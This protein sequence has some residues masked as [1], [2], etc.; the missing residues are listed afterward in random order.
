MGQLLPGYR[1]AI[2]DEIK[3]SI[4]S[5][6]SQ[7]YAFAGNPVAYEDTPPTVT[8]DSYNSAFVNNWQMIFGK[9]IAY[10]DIV[11][12]IDNNEW[13]AGTVYNRYDNTVADLTNYYVITP[14]AVVDASRK[15]YKC[16]DVP[17]NGAPSTIAPSEVLNT[18]FT[19]SDGYTWRYITSITSAQYIKTATADYV[20]VIPDDTAIGAAYEHSGV[21]VVAVAN[22]GVGYSCHLEGT[23]RGITN[24]TYIQ[25]SSAPYTVSFNG[26]SNVSTTN[27]T[28]RITNANNIFQVND[29]IVYKSI[30]GAAINPL[31]NNATYYIAF[32]NSSVV[33]LSETADGAN[34]DLITVG[35]SD[36]G[37]SIERLAGTINTSENF[38]TKNSI[39]FYN[40]NAPTSQLRTITEYNVNSISGAQ[41][42]RLDKPVN[43]DNIAIPSI[44]KISPKVVFDTDGNEEPTAISVVNSFSNSISSIVVLNSGYGVSWA[45]VY[46]Q[47]NTT[48]GSGAVVYGIV[49]P[50]GGHGSNPEI[51]LNV[52]GYGLTFFFANTEVGTIAGNTLYNKIGL[53][54][55]PYCVDQIQG[56]SLS[57]GTKNTTPF[58]ANTFSAVLEAELSPPTAFVIGDTVIGSN[59][60][61]RGTV[62][63]CNSTHIYLTGD[64][65]FIQN[66]P[67]VSSS[68]TLVANITINT[69][70][71]IYTKD[72]NPLYVQNITDVVRQDKLAESF[73]LIIKV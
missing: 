58:S 17:G 43:T 66:E 60:S 67:I 54:K 13:T 48:Y 28:I 63:F 19:K 35:S 41:F 52:K 62:A 27:D 30:T 11:P 61:S 20:P 29:K 53:I 16:I 7:Y 38:Y 26:T 44:I 23:V 18:S 68:G 33:T 1:K 9:K 69:L 32:T 65:Y 15:I 34:I 40:P 10:T 55:N 50:P 6:S 31:A 51:E 45:N 70:G 57:G 71:D 59:S 49:P 3:A 37:H 24:S 4:D 5:N 56:L 21:E 42:V 64:K 73:K 12:V 22:G 47:S 46:I 2:I 8:T 39:Y 25:I 36:T 14:P 72:L